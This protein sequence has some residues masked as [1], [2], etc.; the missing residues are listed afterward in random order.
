[1]GRLA[2]LPLCLLWLSLLQLFFLQVRQPVVVDDADVLLQLL[3]LFPT[4]CSLSSPPQSYRNAQTDFKA[5][6]ATCPQT[7]LCRFLPQEEVPAR[8]GSHVFSRK[9]TFWHS[10][11]TKLKHEA[12]FSMLVCFVLILYISQVNY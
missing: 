7:S 4:P 5:V 1:M 9:T 6:S 10:R 3:Q 12:F 2:L 11:R 8:W